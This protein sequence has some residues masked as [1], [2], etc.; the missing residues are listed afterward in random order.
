MLKRKMYP[1]IS[2]GRWA[3]CNKEFRERLSWIS[4]AVSSSIRLSGARMESTLVSRPMLVF[5]PTSGII[6]AQECVYLH[7]RRYLSVTLG[8]RLGPSSVVEEKW[9]I[10]EI[11]GSPVWCCFRTSELTPFQETVI[12]ALYNWLVA[13]QPNTPNVCERME[14]C[15]C[16]GYKG[17]TVGL[18]LPGRNGPRNLIPT[19]T[20]LNPSSS[21]RLSRPPLL[22]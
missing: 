15:R 3:T 9:S 10:E 22:P 6:N 13:T 16:G 20:W 14:W 8:G 4:S 18:A 19:I 17:A 7:R 11:A 5:K 21:D 1:R 2:E 12:S